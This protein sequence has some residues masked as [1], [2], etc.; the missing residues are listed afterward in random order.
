M[1]V[2]STE[3][4]FQKNLPEAV[5]ESHK[6]IVT[7]VGWMNQLLFRD[8]YENLILLLVLHETETELCAS[9]GED[10]VE[11]VCLC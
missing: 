11:W 1:K 5:G 3:S 2:Y 6:K 8:M 9:D 7:S 4:T 10:K